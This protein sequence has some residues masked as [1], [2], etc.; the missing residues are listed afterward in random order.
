MDKVYEYFEGERRH[1]LKGSAVERFYRAEWEVLRS[2]EII[3]NTRWND[4]W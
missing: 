4:L 3:P 1:G 2:L